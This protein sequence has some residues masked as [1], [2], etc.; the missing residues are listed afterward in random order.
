MRGK[1]RAKS[2]RR[3]CRGAAGVCC[4]CS[5][6]P[7][8]SLYGQS[9]A[10]LV[11]PAI[12]S[13]Y[14]DVPQKFNSYQT[15]LQP[16]SIRAE[17]WAGAP[18][19]VRD[20]QGTF[21]L[22]CR[23]RSARMPRGQR[24]YEIRLLSSPD[25]LHFTKRASLTR[26]QAAMPGFERPALLLDPKTGQFKLYACGPWQQ[27]PWSIIKFDDMA[28]P[29]LVN[30]ASA[31]AVITP[32]KPAGERD[33]SVIEYKDPVILFAKGLFHCYVTGYIRTLERIFHFTSD[34]GE[35]WQAVEHPNDSRLPLSG[36]HDFFIRPASVL[37]LGV[38]YLF[39]YEGSNVKWHDPV[40]NVLTGLG[41]TFDLHQI[42]DL[43]PA[44]PLIASSTPGAFH[45]WRYSS[46]LIVDEEI[47]IYAE[48]AC[49]D[50]THE[51]RLFR[52]PLK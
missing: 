20:Q 52:I 36:W 27:G 49:P 46:W 45:T 48:V 30:P 29:D 8:L 28:R 38:G 14:G 15:I 5:L 31:H 7:W 23:M 10:P 6:K 33:I 3:W 16:D 24:G 22:A 11:P 35:R 9:V 32:I 42:I 17:W 12:E 34:D 26:E 1:S 18:S 50:D 13:H 47:W 40:Y 43:T 4:V 44:S 39:V 37:P 25:G 19:V 41:F 51:I 21:W 2:L